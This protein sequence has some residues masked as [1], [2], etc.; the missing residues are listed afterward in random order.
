MEKGTSEQ[1]NYCY[2]IVALFQRWDFA[3]TNIFRVENAA[4]SRLTAPLYIEFKKST[5]RLEINR[6]LMGEKLSFQL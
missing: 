2:L 1:E 3:Q 5:A 6:L 4:L